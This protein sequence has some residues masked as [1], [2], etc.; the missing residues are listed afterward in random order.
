M[1]ASRIP[2]SPF[3]SSGVSFRARKLRAATGPRKHL[4]VKRFYG[5]G[6]RADI[7]MRARVALARFAEPSQPFGGGAH[8]VGYGRRERGRVTLGNEDPGVRCHGFAI[9]PD[10]GRD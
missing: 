6:V 5:A 4:P 3:D 9:S 8:Q 1:R 10:V 2:G 7:E